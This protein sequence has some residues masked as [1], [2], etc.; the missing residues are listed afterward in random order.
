MPSAAC[1]IQTADEADFSIAA[2]TPYHLVIAADFNT[3]KITAGLEVHDTGNRIG[4]VT[5]RC[6]V[7]QE[8]DVIQCDERQHIDIYQQLRVRTDGYG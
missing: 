5:G 4:P 8:I 2:G 6:A 7:A 1:E 3:G